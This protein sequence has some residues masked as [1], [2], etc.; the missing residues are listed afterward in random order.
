MDR[1][2]QLLGSRSVLTWHSYVTDRQTDKITTA[3]NMLAYSAPS[4]KN[5]LI[6]CRSILTKVE[7]NIAKSNW[8]KLKKIQ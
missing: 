7:Q 6:H 2:M 3:C 1:I 4:N 8:K 5:T